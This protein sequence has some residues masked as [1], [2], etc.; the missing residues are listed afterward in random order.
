MSTQSDLRACLLTLAGGTA[1]A[2]GVI[3]GGRVYFSILPLEAVTANLW[4]CIVLPT[5]IITPDNT[6]CGAADLEDYRVQID[7]YSRSYGA[8]VTLRTSVFTAIEAKFDTALRINE[9]VDYDAGL[10]LHRRIIE[11][12]LK[13]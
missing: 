5:E 8:L 3:E 12:M 2:G 4:P 6:V 7:L 13:D 10:K 11:Y 9:M 1:G